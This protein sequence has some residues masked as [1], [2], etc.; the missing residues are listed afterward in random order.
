MKWLLITMERFMLVLS[1]FFG[2]KCVVVVVVAVPTYQKLSRMVLIQNNKNIINLYWKIFKFT[3]ESS[4]CL[5]IN[6]FCF[7]LNRS[8]DYII[9]DYFW[10]EVWRSTMD[11]TSG[12]ELPILVL[13]YLRTLRLLLPVCSNVL[14][15][16]QHQFIAGSEYRL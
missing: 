7:V 9:L 5:W 4:Q 15:R 6:F 13:R 2:K 12:S 1:D 16:L 10:S 11:A 8:T 14:T 3:S